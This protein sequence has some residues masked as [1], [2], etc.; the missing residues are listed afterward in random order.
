MASAS[1]SEGDSDFLPEDEDFNSSS[2]ISMGSIDSEELASLVT[3]QVNHDAS[4]PPTSLPCAPPPSTPILLTARN[5]PLWQVESLSTLALQAATQSQ[6][7]NILNGFFYCS[8][9]KSVSVLFRYSVIIL[10]FL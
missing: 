4:L 5:V 7:V 9:P 6:W 1:D 3:D 2:D 8:L 10:I